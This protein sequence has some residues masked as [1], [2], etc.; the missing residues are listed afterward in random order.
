M[1]YTNGRYWRAMFNAGLCKYFV[2]QA[3]CSEPVHGYAI[4]RWVAER[5]KHNCVPSEGAV[6]PILWE[7]E[8]CGCVKSRR[9]VVRGRERRVYEATAKGHRSLAVA[10]EVLG[11][12]LAGITKVV[13]RLG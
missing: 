7:F 11:E 6:Y 10:G 1:D 8:K 12:C 3:V 4:V 9:E 5:T 13:C 2:L